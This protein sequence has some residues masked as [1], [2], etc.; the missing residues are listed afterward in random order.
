[1]ARGAKYP[2]RVTHRGGCELTAEDDP[3]ETLRQVIAIR[4][5][6]GSTRNPFLREA[7]VGTM[8]GGVYRTP[9]SDGALQAEIR[10]LFQE[11]EDEGRATLRGRVV[12]AGPDAR[13]KRVV[14]F[15]WEN[16]ETGETSREQV[17]V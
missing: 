15:E 1:M 6:P 3:A 13:G 10:K 14:A 9:L 17:E 5:Y 11:L 8:R 12:T 2:L 7:G 16:L 4:L